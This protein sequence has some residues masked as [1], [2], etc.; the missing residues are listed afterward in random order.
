MTKLVLAFVA[1]VFLV[2]CAADQIPPGTGRS[3]Q[4]CCGGEL[5]QYQW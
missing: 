2:G 4:L 5:W 1:V 3:R